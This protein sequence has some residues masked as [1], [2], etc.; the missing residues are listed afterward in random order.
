MNPEELSRCPFCGGAAYIQY[1]FGHK[2]VLHKVSGCPLK[3][4][5]WSPEI[6]NTRYS[7]PVKDGFPVKTQ[8]GGKWFCCKCGKHL[9]DA[10]WCLDCDDFVHLKKENE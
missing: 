1:L 2:V 10:P 6:W 4:D 7:E 8:L 3:V 5:G 9:K